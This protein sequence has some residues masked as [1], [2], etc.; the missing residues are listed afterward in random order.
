MLTF[1]YQPACR[2]MVI[3]NH[4]RRFERRFALAQS[5]A[6]WVL[7]KVFG[8]HLDAR[9]YHAAFRPVF[10]GWDWLH[11]GPVTSE[12]VRNW[13]ASH[14]ETLRRQQSAA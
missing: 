2:L 1:A 6:Y 3:A 8:T 14:D 10:E 13:A 5:P 11:K 7:W 9:Q 4:G 12:G